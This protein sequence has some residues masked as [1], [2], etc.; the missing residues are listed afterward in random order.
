MNILNP[1]PHTHTYDYVIIELYHVKVRSTKPCHNFGKVSQL[2]YKTRMGI[3]FVAFKT[4]YRK[5]KKCKDIK[6]LDEREE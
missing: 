1:G 3:I 4:S 5:D 2:I 6:K